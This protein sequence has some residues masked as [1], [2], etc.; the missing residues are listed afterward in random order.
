MLVL[1]HDGFLERLS[2]GIGEVEQTYYADLQL[3][4]FGA[5]MSPRFTGFHVATFADALAVARRNHIQLI[6]DIKTPGLV[7]QIMSTLQ[8][9]N[10]LDHVRWP[11]D[12]DEVRKL[13][14]DAN[15]GRDE[16]W[17]QPGITAEQVSKLHAEHKRVIATL[18]AKA[19][20]ST[21]LQ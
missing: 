14:P 21:S 18:S 9:E 7:P 3:R 12:W 13:V 20:S 1:N 11:P 6:L 4:D 19:T 5:W 2:D 10:M 16:S 8:D 17:V 15:V